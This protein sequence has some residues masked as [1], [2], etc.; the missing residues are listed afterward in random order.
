MTDD[1]NNGEIRIRRACRSDIPALEQLIR[2]SMRGLGTQ[3][4]TPQQVESAI[5]YLVGVDPQLIDDGTYFVAE[6]V[7]TGRIV[8]SGGWSFHA[9][10]AGHDS[11]HDALADPRTDSAKIRAIF[12]HPDWARRGIASRLMQ[13][14][15]EAAAHA[16]YHHLELIAT[17]VGIPLYQ[18]LGYKRVETVEIALPDGVRV[19]GLHMDKHVEAGYEW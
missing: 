5:Q 11:A 2:D 12:V 19:K 10:M 9:S 13:A 16:G 15:E 1:A 14:S 3:K 17:L 6:D 18:K 4:Y 8:G 7:K